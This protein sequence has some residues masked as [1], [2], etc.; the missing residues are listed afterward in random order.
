MLKGKQDRCR[1][2]QSRSDARG[3]SRR[4]RRSGC[5]S[6]RRRSGAPG[7]KNEYS[8]PHRARARRAPTSSV[9]SM[10]SGRHTDT[11]TR[12][13][14]SAELVCRAGQ[15]AGTVQLAASVATPG[16]PRQSASRHR[17]HARHIDC[18]CGRWTMVLTLP[19]PSPGVNTSVDHATLGH[20]TV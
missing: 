16:K 12:L 3:L 15:P 20:A 5:A 14:L 7:S 1:S 4:A 11:R 2:G 13:G 18:T 8:D 19:F 17:T 10:A 9:T 6:R